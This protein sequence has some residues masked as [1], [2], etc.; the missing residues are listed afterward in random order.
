MGFPRRL[1]RSWGCE[2]LELT[3]R[4]TKLILDLVALVEQIRLPV[5]HPG[6]RWIALFANQDRESLR[7]S[8]FHPLLPSSR[9]EGKGPCSLFFCSLASSSLRIPWE[10]R[11]KDRE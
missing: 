1:P 4:L 6:I 2:A 7:F 9:R 5:S 10:W 11:S 3:A 8:F